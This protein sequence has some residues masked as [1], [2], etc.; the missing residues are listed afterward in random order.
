MEFLYKAFDKTGK[1]IQ[2]FITAS[3]LFDAKQKIKEQGLIPLEIKEYKH[4]KFIRSK[5]KDFDRY[6][7]FNQLSILLKSGLN[8]D[9]AIRIC[10][11]S[12]DNKFGQRVLEQILNGI[13]SGKDV[14]LAFQETGEFSPFIIS[15]IKIG[16]KTGNLKDAFSNIAN[17]I[18]FN[19]RF[20]SE[21]K[22]AMTYPLFLVVASFFTLLGI[23]K[24]VIPK[25]FSVFTDNID[26]LPLIA[27]ILYNLSNLINIKN[28]FFLGLGIIILI[29]LVKIKDI[30][31]ISFKLLDYFAEIPVLKRFLLNLE[32]SR[33]CY[34]ISSMLKS[35]IE[36]IDALEYSVE[37]I[38]SVKLKKSF[39]KTIPMIKEGKSITKIFNEIE[40]LP[41]IFKGTIK[42]AEESGR[43]ADIFY[44]LY[45][46]FDETFKNDMR[47]IINLVEPIII[48]FVG[49]IIGIIVFSL[50]LTIMSV[51]HIRL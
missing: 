31:T 41:S 19:I 36:F 11:E 5:I 4:A 30:K 12:L 29:N 37:L 32:L 17:Y 6:R 33:F 42:V 9:Y 21:I 26:S 46:Y 40:Y 14:Y 22:N 3:N 48:T 44:E 39:K 27:K 43:L 23:L 10:I 1:E 24:I 8:L 25:F 2:G 28:L 35:G 7:I 15:M 38:K 45:Q 49:I 51:S 13:K 18:Y 50:I 34:S 20:K 16:E 47:K